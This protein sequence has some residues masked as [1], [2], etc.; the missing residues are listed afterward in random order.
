MYRM[1]STG[2][3]V[4]PAVIKI[5]LAIVTPPNATAFPLI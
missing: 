4:E 1:A 3:R 2:F 5:F